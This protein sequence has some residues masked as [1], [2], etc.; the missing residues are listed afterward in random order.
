[1]REQRRRRWQVRRI[2]G[3]MDGSFVEELVSDGRCRQCDQDGSRPSRTGRATR[4]VN[5]SLVGRR[6]RLAGAVPRYAGL[7]SSRPPSVATM[8]SGLVPGPVGGTLGC[9]SGRCGA[10]RRWWLEPQYLSAYVDDDSNLPRSFPVVQ[11]PRYSVPAR[12]EKERTM[13]RWLSGRSQ[14]RKMMFRG[15]ST[16]GGLS[17]L[18]TGRRR[19]GQCFPFYRSAKRLE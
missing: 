7:L 13:V 18:E 4:L 5:D 11:L 1:M 14:E 9:A 8:G 16:A 6:G 19:L 15:R 12:T 17:R 3:W 2:D 10:L